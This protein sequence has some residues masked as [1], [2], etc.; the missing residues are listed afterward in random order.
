MIRRRRSWPVD[1]V[2]F[3]ITPGEFIVLLGESGCGKTTTLKMI[4]RLCEPTRGSIHIDGR[5]I[6]QV[7][8]PTLRRGI[9]YVIQG[10]G[11]FPHQTIADNIATVPRLLGWEPMRIQNRVDELLELVQLS[12]AEYRHRLPRQLSGG[13]RQRIGLA[14]ALAAKPRIMLMDEPFGALDP[15]T[16]D[17]LQQQFLQLHQQLKLTTIMVT[18]DMT[19]ALLLA[20]RI[21]VMAQGRIVQLATPAELL[22]APADEH[23]RHLMETPKRQARRLETM[24]AA[25]A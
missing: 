9:G 16:R 4:N 24:L 20:D 2:S 6:R 5:D 3:N 7:D 19:E 11:L 23:V 18:H 21:A 15:L 22:K 17:D 1:S 25:G 13:Q 8:P 14:R 10:V 12:P